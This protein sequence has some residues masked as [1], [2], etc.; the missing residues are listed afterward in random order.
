[1][2]RRTLRACNLDP[3]AGRTLYTD[4]EEVEVEEQLTQPPSR[5][6]L[7]GGDYTDI[8]TDLYT[9]TMT[10]DLHLMTNAKRKKQ[11]RVTQLGEYFDDLLTEYT[12]GSDHQL[13]LLDDPWA[14]WLQVGR[15]KYPVV[16]RMATNFLT[17]PSTSCDCERAF[18]S[19]GQTITC[20]CN[21]LSPAVTKAIQLQ[22]NW[23]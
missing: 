6:K 1:M 19:A 15:N 21:S 20:D 13:Q 17:I 16:F 9:K 5:R 23:I 4:A 22:K 10:V 14:W 3:C 12:N 2:M 7:P 18:S 11:K 8:H